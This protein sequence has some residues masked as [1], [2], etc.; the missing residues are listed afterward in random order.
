MTAG[1]VIPKDVMHKWFAGTRE[2]DN[3]IKEQFSK[4]VDRALSGDPSLD[5]LKDTPMVCVDS[6]AY[7]NV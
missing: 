7:I 4:D 1:Q 3:D 5:I 2:V 6:Y